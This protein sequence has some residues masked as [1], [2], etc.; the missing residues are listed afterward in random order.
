MIKT[1]LAILLISFMIFILVPTAIF[2]DRPESSGLAIDLIEEI[3]LGGTE[4]SIMIRGTELKNPILLFLH[5]GPGF[6]EMPFSYIDSKELEKN[7]I[8]VNWDQ[9]GC[10]KSAKPEIGSDKISLA[11]ILSDA[12][13]LV[14]YLK[15]RF[16]KERIFLLGHSWGSILGLHIAYKHPRDLYAYI[17][18]GQV[19]DSD[20]GERISYMYALKKAQEANDRASISRLEKIGKPPY[21]GYDDLSV[22]REILARYGG[23]FC[24]MTY[25]DLS[26][27]IFASPDYTQAEKKN[28]FPGFIK[29]HNM[30]W[31]EVTR[32]NLFDS[33][34]ELKVP[35][36][37]F[38]GR[39]DYGCPFELVE[40]YCMA[41]KAPHKE[42]VWF[43]NSGHWPNLEE[44]ALFQN[45]LIAIKKELLLDSSS[46]VR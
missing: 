5:G 45:R 42:M 43:E 28:F 12:R 4:Q 25:R 22:Q 10:G 40:M 17:G 26:G 19:V 31:R 27:M 7:F 9:R 29:I 37:F 32:V 1:A 8:V 41:I 30:L 39:H 44:P 13:E 11:R 24:K 34:R 16:R 6:P 36:Y 46:E 35:V 3:F 33:I 14:K 23:A 2:G 18:M 20:A 38:T 15:S 21:K